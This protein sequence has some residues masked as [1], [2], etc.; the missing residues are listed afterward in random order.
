MASYVAL[1]LLV[2]VI[3]ELEFDMF[4]MNRWFFSIT[5][6]RYVRESSI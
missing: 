6:T 3:N 5:Y 4:K 1:I 2:H